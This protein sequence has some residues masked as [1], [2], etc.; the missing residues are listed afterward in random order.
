M[1]LEKF[2]SMGWT[3]PEA[4]ALKGK[5]E[6]ILLTSVAPGTPAALANLRPG[7]VITR[8]NNFEIKNAEDFSFVLNEAGSGATVNFTVYRG[9]GTPATTVYT[10]A[11]PP[12]VQPMPLPPQ[13]FNFD[14]KPIDVN[15][16]LGEALNTA[17]AMRLAEEYSRPNGGLPLLNPFPLVARGIETA[18]LSPKA[19]THLGAASGVLV[20][21]VD[22]ESLAARAGLKVFDVI[23]TIEGKP[24]GRT[25]FYYT[26]PK[27]DVQQL[28]LGVV[29]DHRRMEITIVRKDEP[30]KK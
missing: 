4:A 5:M 8:V 25:P 21:Y 22:A 28:K 24:V 26:L 27:G 9:K 23:E 17:R 18:Q 19:A 13:N 29:R 16:K 15:V 7:D 11:T 3:A 10:P 30:Q 14:F 20:L 12:T 1:P 2:Y 6:G